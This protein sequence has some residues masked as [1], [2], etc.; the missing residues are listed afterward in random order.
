MLAPKHFLISSL[1]PFPARERPRHPHFT[2]EETE[3]WR[4]QTTLVQGPSGLV[5]SWDE[6]RA[7]FEHGPPCWGFVVRRA[8]PNPRVGPAGHP[9]VHSPCLGC[10]VRGGSKGIMRHTVVSGRSLS[11]RADTVTHLLTCS[12]MR[13]EGRFSLV[14]SSSVKGSDYLKVPCTPD[15]WIGQSGKS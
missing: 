3:A 7:V 13:G 11:C 9:S 10:P 5:G 8:L 12:V 1:H 15:S 2:D 14:I 4:S 6:P